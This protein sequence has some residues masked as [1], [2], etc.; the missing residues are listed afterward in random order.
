MDFL[1]VLSATREVDLL[2]SLSARGRVEKGL[3]PQC[4]LLHWSCELL[5]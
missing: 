2:G 5:V 1:R 3:Y 4:A